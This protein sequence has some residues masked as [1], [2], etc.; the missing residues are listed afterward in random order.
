[1]CHH[2]RTTIEANMSGYPTWMTI[3]G[4]PLRPFLRWLVL[5]RLL[6]GNSPSGIKT[7]KMFVPPD[8]SDEATEVS[9]LSNCVAEFLDTNSRLHAHPGFGSM[10]HDEFSRFHAAH[11]AHHLGFLIPN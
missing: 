5:P 4:Y 9:A 8:I 10:T 6:S 1:M 7:A 3:L 11:G 2:I